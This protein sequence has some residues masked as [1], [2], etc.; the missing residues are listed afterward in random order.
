MVAF[1][2]Y[3]LLPT[4]ST[5]EETTV[6]N[7]NDKNSTTPSANQ[8]APVGNADATQKRSWLPL[9]S[10]GYVGISGGQ[11]NYDLNCVSGYSC[12]DTTT[13]FKLFTGGKLWNVVGLELS[14]LELGKGHRA[15]GDIRARGID[16]SLIGNLPINQGFSVF[17]KVGSTYGWTR[18]SASAPGISSGKER[19]FGLSY[20]AGLNYDFAS[21]W[22]VRAEWERHRFDFVGANKDTD[23]FS[24]GVTYR[25]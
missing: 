15:G 22:G 7:M 1:G 17:G 11:V 6:N 24:V 9:T 4:L 13:G 14:Y 21:N 5:T 23:L 2:S 12:D 19:G 20:G 25:F 16:L 10:N 18:T 3:L 8:N